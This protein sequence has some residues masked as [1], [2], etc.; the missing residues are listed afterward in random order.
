VT[1]ASLGVAARV[2]SERH[3]ICGD[4]FDEHLLLCELVEVITF[5]CVLPRIY[6]RLTE[7]MCRQLRNLSRRFLPPASRVFDDR[8]NCVLCPRC[9]FCALRLYEVLVNVLVIC[10]HAGDEFEDLV[11]SL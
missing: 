7:E 10:A 4:N 3:T 1:S 5:W 2:F 11:N 9:A 6:D 8:R